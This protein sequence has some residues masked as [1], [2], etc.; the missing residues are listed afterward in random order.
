MTR[1]LFTE[2]SERGPFYT[3]VASVFPDSTPLRKYLRERRSFPIMESRS[4]N[5]RFGTAY[6]SDNNSI[7]VGVGY[8]PS[9][10]GLDHQN[11][12]RLVRGA[13]VFIGGSD[14]KVVEHEANEILRM[15]GETEDP[16][17]VEDY[18]QEYIK[19]DIDDYLVGLEEQ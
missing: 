1:Q 7:L 12:K 3:L 6:L 17:S 10:T 4:P 8:E 18:L 11:K 15:M 13:L 14:K 5:P 9:I 19:R 16:K 2:E